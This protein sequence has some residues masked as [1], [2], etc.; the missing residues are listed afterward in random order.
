MKQ[1]FNT[2]KGN[3]IFDTAM[4]TPG[5]NELLVAVY[6]SVISTGTETMDMKKNEL[7]LSEKLHE[8]K[9]LWDKLSRIIHEKGLNTAI[10]AIKDK[11][12]PEDQSVLFR[13]VG[14]S[15]SGMVVA[16]GQ[17]V[18]GFNPGDRV[19]CAGAGF[20]SHA[21]YAIVPVNLA[22]KM[23]DEVT[24]ESAGFTT[25]GAIAMQGIRRANVTFGETVVITGLGLLGL[26]AVQIAKAWGLVVIGIDINTGRL[27]L[28]KELGADHCFAADE[29]N[30]VQKIKDITNG[31][32]ADAVIIYAA[33]KSSEPANQALNLCRRKGTVV[34]VGSV[35]MDLQ[36]DAMYSKEL[37]FVMSTSYGPGRYDNQYEIKGIDYPI[38]YVRWTENRNMKEF[39]RLLA[40]RQVKVDRLI[41]NSFT[42]EQAQQAYQSLIENNGE[43][44]SAVF[45]YPHEEQKVPVS[46]LNIP[47][48]PVGSVLIR[49]GI[50]GA[51]N[52]IQRNHLANL[53]KLPEEYELVAIAEKTPASAAAIKQKYKLN[54]VTTD[55][56]QILSDPEIDLVVIG[57]HHNLHAFLVTESIK[58]GKH[59]LVE[60][61]LAIGHKELLMVENAIKE[62][63]DVIAAVG[64]NRRYSPL[65]QKAKSVILKNG[66]PV[67]INY[68]VNA[69]HIPPESWVQNLE[70]G[71]GR[72][73]GEVCH[74]VD[75]IAYLVGGNV[76][77]LEAV[78][79]P[80]DSINI[81]S[82]DNLIITMSFDNGSIGVIIYTSVG[83]IEMEK[84]RIEIFSNGSSLVVKDF[85]ELQTFNCEE[86]GIKLKTSDKGHQALIKELSKKL[87]NRESLI[88]PFETDIAM[89][90]LTLSVVDQIHQMSSPE[91]KTVLP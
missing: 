86:Q 2:E 5:E 84:E 27:E 31:Y 48:R 30:L 51:G 37:D 54:Y 41:S 26:L 89:T 21:E 58:S 80:T 74:F 52:F 7:T 29:N 16:K 59:V 85:I 75:L 72:I 49:V 36:R 28:A 35:G 71:G 19:A 91:S 56:R 70:E 18:T 34:I 76:K 43:H 81:K 53:L 78:N 42:I 20:A 11:L 17:L 13:P 63:P 39:V 12:S 61:P 3:G 10:K 50:I 38:G 32:G 46:R 57:T 87:K 90:R 55:F 25:V 65:I 23:P 69:G 60:K 68:R 6:T 22:V 4:P 44:I 83:G 8:K 77:T 73:V 62:K 45:S 66:T 9:V 1:L 33:T 47:Q 88:L 14:Y 40:S 67:V 24:F 15:N 82:E 64:F 79:V